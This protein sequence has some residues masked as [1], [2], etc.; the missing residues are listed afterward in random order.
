M[1]NEAQTN[2][3]EQELGQ[4]LR[5]QAA[6]DAALVATVDG[7]LCAQRQRMEYSLDRL[8]AMGCTFMSLSDTMTQELDMGHCKNVIAE[9][10]NGLVVFLHINA[11][12]VL[13]SLTRKTTALGLLLM[14]SRKSAE[15][16]AKQLNELA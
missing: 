3:L 1:L 15:K 14:H 9:N 7:H 2:I 4:L 6:V 5:D 10:D 8:A 16:I 12:L 13:V 11:D